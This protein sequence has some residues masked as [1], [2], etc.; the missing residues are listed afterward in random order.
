MQKTLANFPD[1]LNKYLK[2]NAK[3]T[4]YMANNNYREIVK[5]NVG[6]EIYNMFDFDARSGEFSKVLEEEIKSDFGPEEFK[7]YND[8]EEETI[9]TVVASP[10][11]ISYREY[12]WSE[13]YTKLINKIFNKAKEKIN[14]NE[15]K[16]IKEA[17]IIATKLVEE[18]LKEKNKNLKQKKKKKTS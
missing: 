16:D 14:N 12:V 7:V 6:E 8:D 2:D 10:G 1:G 11:I 4:Y 15:C 5:I 13:S 18:E 17:L 3:K 9:R